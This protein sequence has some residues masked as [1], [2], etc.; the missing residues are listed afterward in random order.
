VFAKIAQ[1]PDYSR[2]MLLNGKIMPIRALRMN[3]RAIGDRNRRGC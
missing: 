3:S 2:L 1:V